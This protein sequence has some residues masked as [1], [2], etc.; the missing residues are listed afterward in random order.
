LRIYADAVGNCTSL[1][2]VG[3]ELSYWSVSVGGYATKT[4][5]IDQ[6]IPAAIPRDTPLRIYSA[7]NVLES[8]AGERRAYDDC[9]RSAAAIIVPQ[10]ADWGR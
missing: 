2:G 5:T 3:T 6:T 4:F 7:I 10:P 9:A 8:P 1:D